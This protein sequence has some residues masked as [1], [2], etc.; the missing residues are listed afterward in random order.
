[1]GST[2]MLKVLQDS[3]EIPSTVVPRYNEGP[4]D[5]QN[6]SAITRFRYIEVFF[7][8]IFYFFPTS[9]FRVLLCGGY[10][11]DDQRIIYYT[12]LLFLS[13]MVRGLELF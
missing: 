9:L 12:L 11:L 1:M 8:H 10:T 13:L 6:L 5:W 7:F 4:R 3:I 2:F